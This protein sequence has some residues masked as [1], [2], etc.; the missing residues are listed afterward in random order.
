MI[1]A[2]MHWSFCA[3]LRFSQVMASKLDQMKRTVLRNWRQN[4][5]LSNATLSVG[6]GPIAFRSLHG[7][8]PSSHCVHRAVIAVRDLLE[9]SASPSLTTLS[10]MYAALP[11]QLRNAPSS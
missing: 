6:Q 9:K 11:Q 10:I 7:L 5:S 4:S 2:A 1:A 3:P 8:L